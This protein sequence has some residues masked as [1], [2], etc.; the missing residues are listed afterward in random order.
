MRCGRASFRE[1]STKRGD[2]GGRVVCVGQG[3]TAR[4]LLTLEL[5][6]FRALEVVPCAE[7]DCAGPVRLDGARRPC[8]RWYET[9]RGLRRRWVGVLARETAMLLDTCCVAH[10]TNQLGWIESGDAH[11]PLGTRM[12]VHARAASPLRLRREDD[13]SK[14]RRVLQTSPARPTQLSTVANC[15]TLVLESVINQFPLL[16]VLCWSLHRFAPSRCGPSRRCWLGV[17]RDGAACR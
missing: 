2:V 1:G 9:V 6:N 13:P 3:Q 7:A 10:C 12:G 4:A 15:A 17:W 14:L 16:L 5:L 8:T 11:V